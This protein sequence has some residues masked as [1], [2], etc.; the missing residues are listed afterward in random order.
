VSDVVVF[1]EIGRV[2]IR[3]TGESYRNSPTME[4]WEG[5]DAE[6]KP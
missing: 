3:L 4:Y 1:P 6:R 2:S 5:V